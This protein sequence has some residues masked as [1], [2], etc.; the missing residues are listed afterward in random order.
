[1][2]EIY[3]IKKMTFERWAVSF[4]HCVKGLQGLTRGFGGKE[5]ASQCW[6]CQRCIF[7]AWVQ[8]I[9]WRR[10]W[11]PTQ[12]FLPRKS[13]EQRSLAGYSPWS[14]KELDPTEWLSR[15]SAIFRESESWK[16]DWEVTMHLPPP[17]EGVLPIMASALPLGGCYPEAPFHFRQLLRLEVLSRSAEFPFAPWQS[18]YFGWAWIH[19]TD[20]LCCWGKLFY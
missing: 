7:D 4:A 9:P 6:R 8:K 1:M 18:S 19:L 5:S 20:V 15:H 2:I 10:A 17:S 14:H 11:Q 12:V 16:E 3:M 13:H